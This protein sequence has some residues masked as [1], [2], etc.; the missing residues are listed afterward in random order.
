MARKLTLKQETYKNNRIA[1]MGVSESYRSAY[2]CKTMTGRNISVEANKLEQ[3]PRIAPELKVKRAEATERALVTTEDVVRGLLKEALGK[4]EDTTPSAR[5]AAYKH[6][7]EY[8]GGFDANKQKIEHSGSI[9]SL[10]DEQLDK[11]L[12]DLI[13]GAN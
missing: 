9:E 3:D 12:E 5:V 2:D 11:K 1:G 7:S 6:L 13:A 10:S 4:G 8:T